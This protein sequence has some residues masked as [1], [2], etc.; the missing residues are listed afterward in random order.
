MVTLQNR[1]E[2]HGL[3]RGVNNSNSDNLFTVCREAEFKGTSGKPAGKQI[4]RTC[5]D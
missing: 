4:F 1:V 2:E 3:E 5:K